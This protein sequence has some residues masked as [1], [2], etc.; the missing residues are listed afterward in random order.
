VRCDRMQMGFQIILC[1]CMYVCMPCYC[2]VRASVTE[3]A[4]KKITETCIMVLIDWSEYNW[5]SSSLHRLVLKDENKL[6]SY[7]VA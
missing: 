2:L 7:S 6:A 5:F 1:V 4:M 3:P